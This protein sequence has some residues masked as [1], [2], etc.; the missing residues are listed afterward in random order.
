MRLE[1]CLELGNAFAVL[2]RCLV[3]LLDPAAPVIDLAFLD[4][5]RARLGDLKLSLELLDL[6][7][8][9]LENFLEPVG[10]ALPLVALTFDD[11]RGPRPVSLPGSSARASS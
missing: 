9:A 10:F 5:V 3:E 8:L 1:R 6:D 2:P 11:A 7:P 4:L